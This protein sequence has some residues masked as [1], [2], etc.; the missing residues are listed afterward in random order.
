MAINCDSNSIPT[1]FAVEQPTVP[2][3]S[4][5]QLIPS[6]I[7][8]SPMLTDDPVMHSTSDAPFSVNVNGVTNDPQLEA[9]QTEFIFSLPDSYD[10]QSVSE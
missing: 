2:T 5:P 7:I 1:A 10:G 3:N 9:L 8:D 4:T 6:S